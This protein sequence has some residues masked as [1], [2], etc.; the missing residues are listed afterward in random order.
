MS[1]GVSTIIAT[2]LM[3]VITVALAG[4]A[5][6]YIQGIF[7]TQVEGNIQIADVTCN[8]NGDI[9]IIVRNLDPVN[10]VDASDFIVSIDGV[11]Q[12][13]VDGNRTLSTTENTT[14]L[15]AAGRI[16]GTIYST[17]YEGTQ[18]LR[19]VGGGNAGALEAL[20]TC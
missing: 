18:Q 15:D 14:V 6:G 4:T 11:L 13:P 8:S 2:L 7:S 3:L 5:F 17:G 19:L 10:T 16:T 9:R 1:K 12:D 20:V